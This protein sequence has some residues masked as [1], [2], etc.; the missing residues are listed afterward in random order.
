MARAIDKRALTASLLVVLSLLAACKKRDEPA[1]AAALSPSAEQAA[2]AAIAQAAAA[3]SAAQAAALAATAGASAAAPATSAGSATPVL[4][5]VKRFTDKEK[6]ASGSTKVA[7]AESKVYGEPDA[8]KP[9]VASLPK[10]LLVT[11]LAALGADW[12]LVEFPSGI[13]KVSPGWMEA[14]SLVGGAGSASTKPATSASAGSAASA[15]P[16]ASAAPSAA[17]PAP[18]ASA[19]KVRV[20]PGVLRAPPRP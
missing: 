9:S 11:R 12:V 20:K 16:S 13:G 10:D 7:L 17:P 2:S 14:K 5:E 15:K 8:T 19:P 1:P 4:G 6:A 18:S 3:A